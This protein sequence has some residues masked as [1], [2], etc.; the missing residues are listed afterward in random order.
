MMTIRPAVPEDSS[1]IGALLGQL[2]YPS[3]ET[4]VS[5]RLGRILPH[6]DYRAWVAES[7]GRAVGF[8]GA[9]IAHS[10]ERNGM[11]G[12]IL[13]LIVDEQARERGVGSMLTRAAE[14]WTA[15]HNGKHVIVNTANHRA[16]AHRFYEGRGY[17]ATGVRYAKSLG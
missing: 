4:E 3:T 14:D 2:G 8:A 5:E 6:R 1:A 15:E 12:R 16:V 10:F 13:A 9:H 7:Q 11:H 17:T